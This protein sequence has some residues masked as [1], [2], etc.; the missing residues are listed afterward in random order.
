MD[1]LNTAVRDI[2][3][4]LKRYQDDQSTQ[5]EA[6][7]V[8]LLAY[9]EEMQGSL[10]VH[11]Q[12]MA[13]L[14]LQRTSLESETEK[15]NAQVETLQKELNDRE[16]RQKEESGC[17]D[18]NGNERGET[19]T[20]WREA[21]SEAESESKRLRNALSEEEEKSRELQRELERMN[22]EHRREM[23]EMSLGRD[24]LEK[25]MLA[26]KKETEQKEKEFLAKNI[27]H[28]KE[29]HGLKEEI[30]GLRSHLETR[31]RET[32]V[33]L[34]KLKSDCARLQNKLSESK[35]VIGGK[36]KDLKYYTELSQT[37]QLQTVTQ[38]QKLKDLQSELLSAS[39]ENGTLRQKLEG[40][41]Q[42]L[43]TRERS[44]ATISNAGEEQ[45][46][47]SSHQIIDTL[48]SQVEIDKKLCA[49]D[50][51][52]QVGKREERR[53][54]LVTEL[55]RQSEKCQALTEALEA[56][57]TELDRKR[58]DIESLL[59]QIQTKSEGGIVSPLIFFLSYPIVFNKTFL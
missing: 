7:K 9:L 39:E 38:A 1:E 57:N 22:V 18:G 55:K 29:V 45:R 52:L 12:K 44:A 14:Q 56:A 36:E 46:P 37:Y 51:E 19:E 4:L 42:R 53:E 23:E 43:S 50:G 32:V 13:D 28:S 58:D 41:T 16:R 27:L 47:V 10:A 11:Q 5:L 15:L 17:S 21:E 8:S 59:N 2:K 25:Q 20:V 40:A 35:A 34:E 6:E 3:L 24:R 54:E 48:S 33:T 49:M 30:E 31:E 26:F